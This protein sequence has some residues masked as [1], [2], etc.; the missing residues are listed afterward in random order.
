[1]ATASVTPVSA[2]RARPGV[3]AHRAAAA[4]SA[5]MRWLRARPALRN[6]AQVPL[7]IAGLGCV[8]A[9]VIL[10]STVAGL[11]VTG[12]SLLLLEHIVADES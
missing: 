8:D 7:T 11:I 10:A 12:A 6:L 4:C 1:M 2:A 5:G 3:L 9:G